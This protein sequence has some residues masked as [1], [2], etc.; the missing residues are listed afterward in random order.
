MGMHFH[1]AKLLMD[2]DKFLNC[3]CPDPIHFRIWYGSKINTYGL[4][5]HI[6]QCWN[7]SGKY[8]ER[9]PGSGIITPS[10]CQGTKAPSS[11][12]YDFVTQGSGYLTQWGLARSIDGGAP[13]FIYLDMLFGAL[14]SS[15]GMTWT[16]P[17][18]TNTYDVSCSGVRQQITV[19][20]EK[21]T[22][23]T[24]SLS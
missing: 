23:Q 19:Y 16:L 15:K 11:W 1:D 7:Q 10:N 20:V 21:M 12:G 24:W 13:T 6:D 22:S 5:Y 2:G 14:I 9:C 4:A 3:C 18:A 17:A 8:F